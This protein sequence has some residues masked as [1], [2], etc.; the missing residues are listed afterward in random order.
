M[1]GIFHVCKRSR[2]DVFGIQRENNRSKMD[3]EN[4]MKFPNSKIDPERIDNNYYF[5]RN[6]NWNK[7]ITEIITLHGVKERSN[8]VVMLDT[9]YTASPEWFSTHSKEEAKKYF[10]DCLN[11]HIDTFCGGRKDLVVN[12][13]WHQDETSDHLHLVSVPVK[14][15]TDEDGNTVACLSAKKIIGDKY[16]LGKIQDKFYSDVSKKYGLKRGESNS[17]CKRHT[18]A[19][20]W[21][22]NKARM[23]KT[24]LRIRERVKEVFDKPVEVAE[25]LYSSEKIKVGKNVYDGGVSIVKTDDVKRINAQHVLKKQV[26]ESLNE[27]NKLAREIMDAANLDE[28]I[29]WYYEKMK[30][31]RRKRD[32]EERN[33][34]RLKQERDGYVECLEIVIDWLELNGLDAEFKDYL[35][36]YREKKK[37]PIEREEPDLDDIGPE[38][39]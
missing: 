15:D 8:S 25:L 14:Y 27:L 36:K 30:E 37:Q 5:V 31:E 39:G 26:D 13:V 33:S 16:S 29:Q 35:N 10:E 22:E 12:C 17:I 38:L 4:G 2:N 11:F 21:E 34:E 23:A 19:A 18:T 28:R 3:L 24:E 32:N 6:D 20:E 7:K 9:V 1:F